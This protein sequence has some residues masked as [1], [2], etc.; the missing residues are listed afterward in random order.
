MGLVSFRALAEAQESLG[1]R[2]RRIEN[3][4]S[5]PEALKTI[6]ARLQEMKA[7]RSQKGDSK[8][9]EQERRAKDVVDIGRT[10]KHAPAEISSKKAVSRKREVVPTLK[11]N[12]R[13]PR[14]EPLSGLLDE[15]K[16]KQNYSFLEDYRADERK[17][18]KD[19]I[20]KTKDEITKEKLKR[21]LLSMVSMG[22]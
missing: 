17:T 20:K 8:D 10:S 12:Y 4:T 21:A 16:L 13:D 5:D 3:A 22:F 18:L 1:E 7:G 14:F 15:S 6:R 11:R 19:E 9:V 2:K